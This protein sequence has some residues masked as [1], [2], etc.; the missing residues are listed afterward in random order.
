MN[1]TY[2]YLYSKYSIPCSDLFHLIETHSELSYIR[3]IC[4]DNT[5]IRQLINESKRCTINSVPCILITFP[6]GTLQKIEGGQIGTWLKSQIPNYQEKPDVNLKEYHMEQIKHERDELLRLKN[7]YETTLA[8]KAMNPY[9]VTGIASAPNKMD[10]RNHMPANNL[11]TPITPVEI[12][13][14]AP[15]SSIR[16]PNVS[17]IAIEMQKR[18]EQQD[19]MILANKNAMAIGQ[20]LP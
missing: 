19:S 3:S 18:R 15:M 13:R 9:Q 4:I 20:R 8:E 1:T 16:A 6:D 2:I 12:S 11:T 10:V 17:D 5:R 7:E 14:E